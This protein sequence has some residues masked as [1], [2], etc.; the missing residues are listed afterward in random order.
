M[1]PQ[2]KGSHRSGLRRVHRRF[3]FLLHHENGGS[4]RGGGP[5]V[6]RRLHG[7][8]R[9]V[10][11]GHRRRS[12]LPFLS[13]RA[14]QPPLCPGGQDRHGGAQRCPGMQGLCGPGLR[15]VRAVRHAGAVPHHHPGL[16]LQGSGGIWPAHGAHPCALCPQRPQVRLHPGPRLCQ[17]PSGGGAAGEAAG[18]RLHPGTGK[19]PEQAGDGR[20]QGGRHHRLHRL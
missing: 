9:R 3:P 7:R 12:Q 5:P 10:H 11:R 1:G 2:R 16:P 4:E 19:R 8:G 18:I 20:R 14:G 17:P 13:E 6:H 15:G